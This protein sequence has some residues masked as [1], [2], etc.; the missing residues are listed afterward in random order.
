MKER[1]FKEKGGELVERI[2]FFY[3]CKSV[4]KINFFYFFYCWVIIGFES[5]I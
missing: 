2:V 1:W 3:F 4:W 5:D